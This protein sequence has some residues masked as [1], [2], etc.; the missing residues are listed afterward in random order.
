MERTCKICGFVGEY[1][2]D[3]TTAV[4]RAFHGHVCWTCVVKEQRAWRNTEVGREESRRTT[5]DYRLRK[6]SKREAAEAIRNAQKEATS[7]RN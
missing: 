5:A 2:P 7:R 3:A 6:R 4:G 1:T